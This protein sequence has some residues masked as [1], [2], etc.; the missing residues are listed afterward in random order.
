MYWV[1]V[2]QCSS[3][4]FACNVQPR[5]QRRTDRTEENWERIQL[6]LQSYSIIWNSVSPMFGQ[7]SGQWRNE[8]RWNLKISCFKKKKDRSSIEYN[9]GFLHCVHGANLCLWRHWKVSLH[10]GGWGSISGFL[11][12][13][14]GVGRN[15]R[16]ASFSYPARKKSLDT[17]VTGV[18]SH[19]DVFW[20]VSR[21][22]LRGRN[23]RRE[24]RLTSLRTSA[25]EARA[26]E[27][28]V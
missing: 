13:R 28:P 5:V 27:N 26:G 2:V 21:S 17:Q 24:E 9:T 20:L 11:S 18:A 7:S 14:V 15:W 1:I 12:K 8:I 25:W 22:Y 10:I 16:V 6:T 4:Q 23:A 3:A 19:A